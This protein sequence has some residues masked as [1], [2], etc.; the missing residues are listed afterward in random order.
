MV[1]L[2]LIVFLF[3]ELKAVVICGSSFRTPVYTFGDT[4]WDC[5]GAGLLCSFARHYPDKIMEAV[6]Q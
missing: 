5:L 1:L 4:F 3:S 2:V 6:K